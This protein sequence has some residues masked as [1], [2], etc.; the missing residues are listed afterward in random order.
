[1][2][3]VPVLKPQNLTKEIAEISSIMTEHQLLFVYQDEVN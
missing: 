3:K 1:M 2:L